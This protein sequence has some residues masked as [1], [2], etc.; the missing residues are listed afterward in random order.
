MKSLIVFKSI[1]HQN[2]KKIAQAIGQE[3]KAKLITPEKTTLQLIKAHDLVGFGSGIYFGK[4]HRKLF[5]LLDRLPQFHS[6]KVFIFSTS[7]IKMIKIYH[8]KLKNKLKQ[9]GFQ[10]IGEFSCSGWDTY[11][12][13]LKALGGIKKGRPN[14]KD[15]ENAKKFAQKLQILK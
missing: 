5:D 2:T 6:K 8:Q 11:W 10:I 7:G 12:P 3:L 4:H 15:L 14:Q 13:I 1:H 9:K